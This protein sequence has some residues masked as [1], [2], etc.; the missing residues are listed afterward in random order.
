MRFN[1][2]CA[3]VALVLATSATGCRGPRFTGCY[4]GACGTVAPPGELTGQPPTRKS[5]VAT[6]Q[7]ANDPWDAVPETRAGA[8]SDSQADTEAQEI[9]TESEVE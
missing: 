6:A 8:V 5:P 4:G 7:H 3:A 1:R 9:E 2:V